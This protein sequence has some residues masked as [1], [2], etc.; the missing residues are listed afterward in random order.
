MTFEF[1]FISCRKANQKAKQA[2][3]QEAMKLISSGQTLILDTG[4]TALELAFLLKDTEDITVLTPSLAV[5]SVLQFSEGVQTIFLGGT[6]RKG[7]PD[8]TGVLTEKILEMFMVDIA[9]QGADG[10]GL[11]GHMY[12]AD[13]RIASVDQKMRQRAHKVYILCDSS[14]IDKTELASNWNFGPG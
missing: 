10:I 2:I 14:K 12:N 13:M 6:I 5:A 7:N 1:D 11:D 8:L 4:I 9:F 3:A